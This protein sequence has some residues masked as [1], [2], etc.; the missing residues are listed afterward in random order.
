[1]LTGTIRGLS[2]CQRR[3]FS[4]L[5]ELFRQA[6]ESVP[7]LAKDPGNETKLQ[8]YALFKQVENGPPTGS[9]PSFMDPV[10]RAKFDAWESVKNLDKDAAMKKYVDLVTTLAG[11]CLPAHA[12][13]SSTSP[14]ASSP[15]PAKQGLLESIAFPRKSNKVSALKLETITTSISSTGVVTAQMN[16]PKRGNA[17]NMQMWFDLNSLF[18]AIRC[19]SAARVIVLTGNESSFSTGMDLSVFAEMQKAALSEPC[20]GRKREAL[21]EFIDYLQK[22]ISL[23][24]DCQVPVIAAISG[25]CIGGAVDLITSCDLR[26]CTK[27]SVFSVKEVDLAIV[28]D[29]GTLQRLPRLVGEQRARELCLTA[30]QFDSKEAFDMG[31]VLAPPFETEAEMLNA[32]TK[33]ANEIASKSPLTVRGVKRCLNYSRDHPIADSLNHVKMHNASHLLSNDL[34]EAMTGAKSFKG[35]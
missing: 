27:S 4:N 1:M 11:G 21:S 23:A 15:A 29:I 24:E 9:R 10:G 2:R 35:N 22:S 20:E 32:V 30:R 18:S 8:M 28:A 12:S 7:L 17:F 19:D 34:I 14:T 33:K 31:L 26:Y 3:A 6:K 16:R 13:T 25:F 5:S